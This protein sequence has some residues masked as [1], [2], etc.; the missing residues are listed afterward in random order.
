MLGIGYL[1]T[2]FTGR[3]QAF[4]DI[5]A[6]CLVVDK[7]SANPQITPELENKVTKKKRWL[8]LIVESLTVFLVYLVG[9]VLVL[10][11]SQYLF[12]EKTGWW[13]E[14]QNSKWF[15][16]N[17]ITIILAVVTIVISISAAI[18]NISR[19][20][21]FRKKILFS[22]SILITLTVFNYISI[23]GYNQ[24]SFSATDFNE[25][26]KKKLRSWG[27]SGHYS[28]SV[29]AAIDD[30][31]L[32][33]LTGNDE[34]VNYQCTRLSDSLIY[35]VWKSISDEE[36]KNKSVEGIYDISGNRFQRVR[37]NNLMPY[38]KMLEEHNIPFQFIGLIPKDISEDIEERLQDI[39]K[40][41]PSKRIML[42]KSLPAKYWQYSYISEGF[43][44]II[45]IYEMLE[46]ANVKDKAEIIEKYR[47]KYR[48]FLEGID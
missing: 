45:E 32:N 24:I 43:N 25:I 46:K 39:E 29:G 20:W 1:M 22:L 47:K 13:I 7:V 17:T 19:K 35:V 11:L 41:T 28:N 9:I 40:L 15:W 12:E 6:G 10:L 38:C 8:L 21:K 27:G 14:E 4:H 26:A 23:C 48:F 44:E 30:F 37:R 31:L 33:T 5:V 16:E 42:L 36:S 34:I 3:K 2:A 18:Y